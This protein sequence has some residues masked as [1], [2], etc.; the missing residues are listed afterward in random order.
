[1]LIKSG[2]YKKKYLII[3]V[4]HGLHSSIHPSIR[5]PQQEVFFIISCK[6]WQSAVYLLLDK[7]VVVLTEVETALGQVLT[8][9]WHLHRFYHLNMVTAF[10]VRKRS[11]LTS[12]PLFGYLHSTHWLQWDGIIGIWGKWGRSPVSTIQPPTAIINLLLL[13]I[14][15]FLATSV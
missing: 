3:T 14:F 4:N 11:W 10:S 9:M 8:A 13:H 12:P 15:Y 1:M 5:K 6:H 2:Y 7:S